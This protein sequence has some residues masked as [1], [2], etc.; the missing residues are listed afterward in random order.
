MVGKKI[1]F[2]IRSNSTEEYTGVVVYEC[3]L[4]GSAGGY[5][6]CRV[7]GFVVKCDD[8]SATTIFATQITKIH[9]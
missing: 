7:T 5:Q 3:W 9:E 4:A 1:S 6:C 8:G 2:K